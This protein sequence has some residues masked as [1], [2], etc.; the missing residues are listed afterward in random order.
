MSVLMPFSAL[1]PLRRFDCFSHC[2]V[3]SSVRRTL[4]VLAMSVP[5]SVFGADATLFGGHGDAGGRGGNGMDGDSGGASGRQGTQG[6][7][8]TAGNIVSLGDESVGTVSITAGN[9]GDGGRGGD[10]GPTGSGGGSGKIGGNGGNGG[11][12]GK[13]GDARL[14]LTAERV[15]TGEITVM[16]GLNG[17]NGS[18]GSTGSGSLGGRGGAGGQGGLAGQAE[19]SARTLVAPRIS[20]TQRDGALSFHVEALDMTASDTVLETHGT[21]PAEVRMDRIL[22]NEG[23]TFNVKGAGTS[24]YTFDALEVRGG[25]QSAR[26]EGDFDLSGR[27]LNFHIDFT[28]AEG[29]SLLAV[30]GA[31][32]V[33]GMKVSAPEMIGLRGGTAHRDVLSL[34]SAGSLNGTVDNEGEAHRALQGVS[35]AYRYKLQT[36]PGA[37]GGVALRMTSAQAAPQAKAL[38][39]GMLGGAVFLGQGGFYAAGEGMASAIQSVRAVH[40][41]PEF[42]VFGT[43]GGGS[44]RVESGSSLTVR[45]VNMLLGMSASSLIGAGRLTGGLFGEY[46]QGEVESH[47]NFGAAGQGWSFNSASKVKGKSDVNYAGGGLLA[48]YR[49]DMGLYVEGSARTGQSETDYRSHDLTDVLGT[50]VQYKAKTRYNGAHLGAGWNWHFHSAYWLDAYAKGFWM[51]QQ[52][53]RV[54]LSTGDSITFKEITLW[55]ARAGARLNRMVLSQLSLYAGLAYEYEFAGKAKATANTVAARYAIDAPNVRGGTG[56]GEAGLTVKPVKHFPL[57]LSLGVQGYSGQYRGVTGEARV[58]FAF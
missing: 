39:E 31:V 1:N 44:V 53:D 51:Q 12:G 6:K 37:D 35:V 11:N 33:G 36:Q 47:N 43:V 10:G 18:R 34:L 8:N 49:W 40:R 4:L 46:G 58:R 24:T 50:H 27:Q 30:N 14:T 22:L 28:Q 23:R 3:R 56:I 13:G 20:L 19:F 5:V 15:Q 41:Q 57:A 25:L 29:V 16:S 45:G 42:G 32:A 9:G 7:D 48:H 55:R 2:H 21:Q 17:S 38:S 52:S 54:R 26:I